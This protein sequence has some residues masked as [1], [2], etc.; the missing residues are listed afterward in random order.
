MSEGQKGVPGGWVGASKGCSSLMPFVNS[1]VGCGSGG[2]AQG[3]QGY[4][5]Y[6]IL[7]IGCRGLRGGMHGC[8]G[9][10]AGFR[11]GGG[12]GGSHGSETPEDSRGRKSGVLP[13][14][15]LR[16]DASGRP[17]SERAPKRQN[18]EGVPCTASFH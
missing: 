10:E 9:A 11:R 13:D 2:M 4:R 18:R 14:E 1:W 7:L 8:G 16:L 6:V 12:R 3:F 17:A 15:V 5:G